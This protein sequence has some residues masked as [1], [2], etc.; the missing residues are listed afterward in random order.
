[1]KTNTD[2]NGAAIAMQSS[3][4]ETIKGARWH[5]EDVLL[6]ASLCLCCFGCRLF[7]TDRGYPNKKPDDFSIEY[8]WRRASVPPPGHY[9]YRINIKPSGQGEIILTP[10]YA[11]QKVP[12]VS[13]SF[14]VPADQ[15]N[16]VYLLMIRMGLLTTKWTERPGPTIMGADSSELVVIAQGR[17]ITVGGDLLPEQLV[18]AT[19]MYEAVDAL[20]PKDVKERLGFGA[21][22]K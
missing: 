16:K 13:E 21:R 7:Y 18:Q 12:E 6:I 2:L 4:D 19:T 9:E 5:P 1:M 22:L 15:L 20:V 10:G 14:Q 11:W 8:E 3:P 17:R